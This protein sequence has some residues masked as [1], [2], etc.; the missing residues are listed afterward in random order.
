MLALRPYDVYDSVQRALEV[1]DAEM[2]KW[3]GGGK[4]EL[5]QTPDLSWETYQTGQP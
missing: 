5:P 2:E 4:P 3:F 1:P